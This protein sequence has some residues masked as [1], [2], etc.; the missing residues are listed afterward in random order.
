MF[1]T[2][3]GG[4]GNRGVLVASSPSRSRTI[5]GGARPPERSAGCRLAGASSRSCPAVAPERFDPASSAGRELL[6]HELVHVAQQRGAAVDPDNLGITPHDSNAER[7]ARAGGAA[8]AS[9]ARIAASGNLFD[10][11]A[12]IYIMTWESE[13]VAAVKR[14]VAK[15]APL[16]SAGRGRKAGPRRQG[17]GRDGWPGG[18]PGRLVVRPRGGD[19][20]REDRRAPQLLGDRGHRAA[21]PGDVHRHDHRRSHGRAV[22]AAPRGLGEGPRHQDPRRQ[23]IA[24]HDQPRRRSPQGNARRRQD[25]RGPATPA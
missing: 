25:P 9:P 20:V 24:R 13:I 3:R 23:H 6:A 12:D 7:E 22:L 19:Q 14:R 8:T 2:C 21:G 16:Q 5:E 11:R 17:R 1:P 4:T 18:A 15:P 10:A